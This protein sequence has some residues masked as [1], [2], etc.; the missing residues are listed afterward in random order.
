MAESVAIM[1]I[2]AYV[3]AGGSQENP[4]RIKMKIASEVSVRQDGSC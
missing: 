4:C 3:R 2:V 1:L